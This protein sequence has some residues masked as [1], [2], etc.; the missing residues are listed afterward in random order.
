MSK[1][2]IQGHEVDLDKVVE[3]LDAEDVA[4]VLDGYTAARLVRK[5]PTETLVLELDC[6]DDVFAGFIEQIRWRVH[7]LGTDLE[8]ALAEIAA[9]NGTHW[10]MQP[11]T[12]SLAG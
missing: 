3:A 5:L 10:S 2:T 11:G 9:E 6:R 7:V 8:T 12:A 1:V 4:E